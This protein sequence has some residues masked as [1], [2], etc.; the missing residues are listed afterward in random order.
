MITTLLV[1]QTSSSR[2]PARA[3]A[4]GAIV[5]VATRRGT[6][7]DDRLVVELDDRTPAWVEDDASWSADLAACR[8]VLEAHGGS[9]EVE[10]PGSGGFRFHLELPIV[11]AGVDS[12]A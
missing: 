2:A 11:A 9:L 3:G 6:P 10:S 8:R 4:A 7:A 5:T 1:R 12:T